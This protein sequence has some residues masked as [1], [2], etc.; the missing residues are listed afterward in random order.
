[1]ILEIEAVEKDKDKRKERTQSTINKG[2]KIRKN[3]FEKYIVEND[4]V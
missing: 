4:K 1:M 2:N 3:K